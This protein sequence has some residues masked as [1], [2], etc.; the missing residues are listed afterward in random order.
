MFTV[1]ELLPSWV[2]EGV[3]E[4]RPLSLS[5]LSDLTLA[6]STHPARLLLDL[7][8]NAAQLCC[9]MLCLHRTQ[10]IITFKPELYVELHSLVGSSLFN[11]LISIKEKQGTDISKTNCVLWQH[12]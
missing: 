10:T 7:D 9:Q 5:D 4:E 1:N 6:I 11:T 2:S 12:S 3:I 8:D